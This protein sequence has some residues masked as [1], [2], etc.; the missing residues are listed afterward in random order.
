MDNKYT[1]KD[2][3]ADLGIWQSGHLSEYYKFLGLLGQEELRIVNV[4]FALVK[5]MSVRVPSSSAPIR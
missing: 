5:Q 2:F 4:F 3:L 1:F